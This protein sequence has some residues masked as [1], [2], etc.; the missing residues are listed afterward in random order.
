MSIIKRNVYAEVTA[1]IISQ[2]EA[3]TIPWRKPWN[4]APASY[5]SKRPYRGVN[6]WLLDSDYRF[7][8]WLTF[9]QAKKLGGY[10]KK[11]ERGTQIIFWNWMEKESVDADTGEEKVKKFAILKCYTV[12][13][14][15]Q[16]EGIDVEIATIE[17]IA[18]AEE[19]IANYE[20]PPALKIGGDRATYNPKLDVIHIPAMETFESPA[21]YYSTLFHEHIHS[22]GHSSRLDRQ[23][24]MDIQFGSDEYSEEELIAEMGAAFLCS[25]SCTELIAKTIESSASYIDHWRSRLICRFQKRMIH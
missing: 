21:A 3:G 17:P 19:I 15:G 11:G 24:M 8:L 13:N 5:I 14:V 18:S 20:N 9:Q 23:C 2:L 12:F 10:V 25:M 1:K 4:A 16:C 6:V 7:P 22:T